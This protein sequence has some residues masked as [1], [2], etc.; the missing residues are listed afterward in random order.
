[1]RT[2]AHAEVAHTTVSTMVT[3]ATARVSTVYFQCTS[4]RQLRSYRPSVQD[5]SIE[6]GEATMARM[7]EGRY[8]WRDASVRAARG[9]QRSITF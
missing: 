6:I 8:E 3:K 1:M 5:R 7:V 2:E 4:R 9:R